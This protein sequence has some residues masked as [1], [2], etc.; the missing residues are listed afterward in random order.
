MQASLIY[1]VLGE[2]R[3]TEYKAINPYGAVPCLVDGDFVLTER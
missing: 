2:T 1:M 3:T